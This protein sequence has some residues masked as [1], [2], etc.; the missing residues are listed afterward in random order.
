[1]L[2]KYLNKLEYNKIL[3]QVANYCC[4]YIG[5]ENVFELLPSN[6]KEIVSLLLEQTNS[7]LNLLYRKGEPTI[8]NIANIE[9]WIKNLESYN[10]L[11]AK[12]L[13][14]VAGVLQTA[15]QLREYFFADDNFDLSEFSALEDLFS[16]LYYNKTIEDNIFNSIIDENTISDDASRTLS[17]LRRNRRKLEQD[18]RDKLSNFLHSS[19][20]KYL[21]DSIITIRN[22]RFVIPI[23]EEYKDQISGAILDMSAS[24]STVYIEPSVIF[25][26]NNKINGIKAEEAIEIEKILKNLSLSLFPIASKLKISLETIGKIDFIFAKA[27]YSKKI[28]GICPIINDK[29]QIFLYGARHPLIDEK[30]VVPIDIALGKDYTSL[31]ITGPNTGGKTVTLKTVGLFCLIACSGIL[32]PVNEN[33][34]I[35]VFDNIFADIGDEQSIQESLSTFSSHMINII[36]ILNTATSNS[37]VLIDELGS[38]TD[39]VEGSSLAISIL[40]HFYKIGAL[41]ICTTHYTELKKYALTH[42]GFENASSDFDVEN[43]KPT[44]KLLIGVP[45]K[46]NAFAIS[47]K[48]GLSAEII[49]RAQTFIKQDD[50]NIETLLK[51]IYDDKLAIELE[52]EKMQKN[53]NQIEMLRKSLERD[54]SK[55]NKEAENIIS[56]AK[57]KARNILLDA[58]EE[59]NEIIKELNNEST[60]VK[61]ANKL[62][63]DLNKSI[64]NL[65]KEN[66]I[67]DISKALTNDEIFI[68]QKVF[69]KKLNLEGIILSL[70][71]KSNEVKVQLG[72]I[73]MNINIK[74][75]CSTSNSNTNNLSNTKNANHPAKGVSFINQK[76]KNISSEINVI[77]LNVDQA[78]PIVDKYLDDCYM[79]NL[80]QARIVHGKGTGKLREGIHNFLRKHPHVKSFRLGTFGEGEAGVTIVSFK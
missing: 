76:S 23:K 59:A 78:I 69:Y 22:D 19:Y 64:N 25:E 15:S 53:A 34:S 37:L 27:K 10:S 49:N 24:G 29:K 28:N 12:A 54:N 26:L 62:R 71:N 42:P 44:Y 65:S 30:S 31:L 40:E 38:G 3:E 35:Y 73:N 41:T 68:G 77:G 48:L 17:T 67:L 8:N 6:N 13:L 75:L 70:P 11:S 5:R 4:T 45:G 32:I 56:D 57:L 39:P 16:M 1:M 72:S 9:L 14:E 61:T 18:I 51:N 46:S 50:I 2:Q 21:M 66:A 36:N 60:N 58:K 55:L 47:K 80:E 79:A 52:K 7:A 20:S 74:D 43:L 33:S 63:N